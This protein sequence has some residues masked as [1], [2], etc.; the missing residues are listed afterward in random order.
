[1]ERH[2]P[3]KVT[4]MTDN[5]QLMSEELRSLN[6]EP[7]SFVCPLAE[8]SGKGI[9]F[10]YRIVDGSRTGETVMLGLV[11]PVEAG[12]WPEVTPHWVHICPPDT[13]LEEQVQ[14]HRGNGR[15]TVRRYLDQEGVEWMAIS[16]PVKDFWDQIEDPNGKNMATY[17]EL[18]VRRVWGAR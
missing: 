15:G 14:A 7:E 13:V 6:Y 8:C 4:L 11:I 3:R 10:Q 2:S 1:M 5:V 18:H 17:L 12:A 9:K 16:A